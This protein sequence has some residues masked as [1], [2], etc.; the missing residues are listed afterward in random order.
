MNENKKLSIDMLSQ[1][2]SVKAQ[3]VGSVYIE[4]T[5]LIEEL[6]KDDFTVYHNKH[7]HKY[8]LYHVHSVNP[9]Y[10]HLMK[11]KK[12]VSICFVHFLPDTLEGSIKLP[13]LAFRIF[14]KYVTS[15]YKAAK[16]IVVVNPAFIP[17]LVK[18]GIKK[19]N[20][21]YIPNFVSKEDFYKVSPDKKKEFRA[22]YQIPQDKFVVLGVGQVQ[23]RK[24][25]LDFID[26]SKRNPDM[27]FI[28]AGGF[29]FGNITEGYSELKK[30][31]ETKRENLKFLGIRERSEMQEI[32]N[33]ADC[34]LLPSYN[35]LFPMALLENCNIGNPYVVR[36][37]D[38]YKDIL[39]G[40]YPK[41]KD[42]EGFSLVL[43]KIKDDP[44]YFMKASGLSSQMAE[45]YSRENVYLLWRDYYRRIY[46][47]YQG[48][49][50]KK[51]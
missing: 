28:W 24:G 23:T 39:I 5:R 29:S 32:Y 44:D 37:L 2:T 12:N 48:T 33:A 19:E 15:F 50:R 8:D 13:K 45:K 20:I 25:I 40:D 6:G 51:K 11:S 21:S 35:E 3:G 10:Y 17:D 41:A 16:E 26:I 34:F 42:N 7:S 9:Q 18:F 14:K 36:D 47:K 43:R 31:V 46:A 4:Q 30:E 49:I 27:Y 1:A 38:L 22:K